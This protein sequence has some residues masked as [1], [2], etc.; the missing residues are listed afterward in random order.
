MRCR[1]D[2]ELEQP[3]AGML[4]GRRADSAELAL[5]RQR[6][7]LAEDEIAAAAVSERNLASTIP[8]STAWEAERRVLRERTAELDAQLSSRRREHVRFVLE[9]PAAYLSMAPGAR[10]DQPR[11]R[12]AWQQAAARIEAYRFDHAVTD[13]R[14]PL[15]S[16]PSDKRG[17]AHRQRAHPDLQRARRD[18]GQRIDRHFRPLRKRRRP[19]PETRVRRGGGN[20]GVPRAAGRDLRRREARRATRPPCLAAG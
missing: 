5:E 14:D 16:P 12:R 1:D 18:L 13:A 2:E 20:G 10:P 7:Q 9:R 8:D 15:G 3:A 11:G 19:P 6:L 4:G 17:R